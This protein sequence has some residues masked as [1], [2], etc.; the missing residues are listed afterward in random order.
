M[1][2]LTLLSLQAPD[3]KMMNKRLRY[4]WLFTVVVVLTPCLFG[5][6]I[7][8]AQD[9]DV[10]LEFDVKKLKKLVYA[11][12]FSPWLDEKT[13]N[14]LSQLK[15]HVKA[16]EWSKAFRLIDE[17]PTAQRGQLFPAGRS[18]WL[19]LE[20][21][22]WHLLVQLPSEGRE[23]FRL[24]FN[25]RAKDLY[26]RALLAPEEQQRSMLS[27]IHR[28]YFLTTFGDEATESLGDAHFEQG[29]FVAAERCWRSIVTHHADSDIPEQRLLV[30]IGFAAHRQSDVEALEKIV[31]QIGARFADATIELGGEAKPALAIVAELLKSTESQTPY[32]SRVL[33][34]VT[35]PLGESKSLWEVNL[36]KPHVSNQAILSS[37]VF[38]SESIFVNHGPR[39]QS[40]NRSTGKMNWQTNAPQLQRAGNN[41][42]MWIGMNQFGMLQSVFEATPV[43]SG[44]RIYSTML[45]ANNNTRPAVVALNAKD[46]SQLWNS[47]TS[48]KDYVVV[49]NPTVEG[50]SVYVTGFKQPSNQLFVHS[51]NAD[52]GSLNWSLR[53]GS[54]R[55]MVNDGQNSSMPW[56]LLIH[57]RDQLYILPSDGALVAVNT[58]RRQVSW[59]IKFQAPH[60]QNPDQFGWGNQTQNTA[61]PTRAALFL[62]NDILYLKDGNGPVL[63]AFD[64]QRKKPL[65]ARA[66]DEKRE[67]VAVDDGFIYLIGD[68]IEARSCKTGRMEWSNHPPRFTARTLVNTV[69]SIYAPTV[70][71][72]YRFSKETGDTQ[73]IIRDKETMG[74]IGQLRISGDQ[75]L[76]FTKG[77]I[78]AFPI[79]APEIN[80]P[81]TTEPETTEPETTEPENA[82]GKLPTESKQ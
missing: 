32:I 79:V 42:Q 37:Y 63:M 9:V 59:L 73:E 72:I 75:L 18:V 11:Q 62:R 39:M 45:H 61:I 15:E 20:D 5:A 64:T 19:P 34:A 22:Y 4:E 77:K 80:E 17:Q 3:L 51:L 12:G 7:A 31:E 69:D 25:G 2:V 30:K 33:P 76:M 47:G 36:K 48:L 14:Q 43:V 52:D 1:M 16:K 13:I 27:K 70:R 81:E 82:P 44:G 78:R 68:D 35:I 46:G 74:S 21:Y 29:N 24:Y 60:R 10:S 26:E 53:V 56:P 28:S 55:A 66:I 38:T 58:N 8:R 49:G 6:R 71:G 50:D 40:F 65:W 67:L 57:Y 23:A 41:N 54:V